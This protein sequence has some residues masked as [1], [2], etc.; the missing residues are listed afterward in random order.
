LFI[1]I[2]FFNCLTESIL[3]TQAGVVFFGFFNSLLFY[4]MKRNRPN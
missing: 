2:V 4:N 3:E 1:L